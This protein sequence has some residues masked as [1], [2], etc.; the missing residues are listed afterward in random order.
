MNDI[1]ALAT[2]FVRRSALLGLLMLF[3]FPPSLAAETLGP[4]GGTGGASATS[5]C[6]TL[7]VPA[8]FYR[9]A[10]FMLIGVAGR[11]GNWLDQ[12]RAICMRFTG[13]NRIA[14][15]R[16]NPTQGASMGGQGGEP[17]QRVCPRN[18][19]VVGFRGRAGSYLDRL[20]IACQAFTD[21]GHPIGPVTWLAPVGGIGGGPFGPL[22]CT[23]NG[24]VQ[25]L[26][27]RG[28]FY[29]DSLGLQCTPFQFDTKPDDE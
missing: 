22:R 8:P 17:F 11:S 2:A 15:W 3:S 9:T 16:G 18:Q 4:A 21:S 12:I 26:S 28:G 10:P 1:N 14:I 23:A 13:V 6:G 24:A 7:I 5:A 29:V 20:Q 19:A 25:S 27:G